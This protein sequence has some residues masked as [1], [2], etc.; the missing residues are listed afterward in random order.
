MQALGAPPLCFGNQ[1]GSRGSG[2]SLGGQWSSGQ[3]ASEVRVPTQWAEAHSQDASLFV[4]A[5]ASTRNLPPS[6]W[7]MAWIGFSSSA[8]VPSPFYIQVLKDL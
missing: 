6:W 4:E 8:I 1:N 2:H 3:R 7:L 5:G